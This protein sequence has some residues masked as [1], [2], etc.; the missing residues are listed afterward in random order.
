MYNNNNWQNDFQR[1]QELNN[2]SD[3]IAAALAAQ[4]NEDRKH[5]LRIEI[6]KATDRRVKAE[7]QSMLDE[8]ERKEKRNKIIAFILLF[9]VMAVAA[10]IGFFFY[11]QHLS[12]KSTISNNAAAISSTNISSDSN[13]RNNIDTKQLTQEQVKKWVYYHMKNDNPNISG[14]SAYDFSIVPNQDSELE[15]SVS[16]GGTP[17]NDYLID[18]SGDLYNIS[19]GQK[20]LISKNWDVSNNFKLDEPTQTDTKQANSSHEFN[21]KETE[22]S[23]TSENQS[24]TSVNMIHEQ[25]AQIRTIMV[26]NQNLDPN[27]LN[28]IPDE[29][30]LAANAGNATNTQIAETAQNLINK[31]PTL[32]K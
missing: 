22:I 15:I 17:V 12:N 1:Q 2:A 13:P 23:S 14:S 6:A 11:N 20:T 21:S 32:K 16:S 7:L 26:Q 28:N 29:E 27:I 4:K 31:Y 24:E 18:S 5:L 30:I 25:A 19:S 10:F 3:R 9:I 8:I